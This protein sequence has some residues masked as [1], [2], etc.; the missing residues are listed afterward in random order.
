MASLMMSHIPF[1]VIQATSATF[2]GEAPWVAE[3]WIREAGPR[4][5]FRAGFS[6]AM[7]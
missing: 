4:L 2:W 3:E 7:P 5:V 1:L 6:S